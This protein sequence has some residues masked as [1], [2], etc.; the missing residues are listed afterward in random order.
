MRKTVIITIALALLSSAAAI[1]QSDTLRVSARYTTHVIF[2]TDITYADKSDGGTIA[3]KVVE[4]NKNMIALKARAPFTEPCSV[5]ALESNGRMWTFIVVYDDSP[6]RLIVDTRRQASEVTEDSSE[7][8]QKKAG[9]K[10]TKKERTA[11][12]WKSG[13]A[14]TLEEVS[15]MG[16][17]LHHIGTSGYGVTVLCENIYSYSDITYMVFSVDN[18]SGISYDVTDATFVIESR[19]RSKRTVAYDQT[20]FPRSRYGSLTAG[21]GQKGRIVYS[22]DKMTLSKDQA[23]RVYLY[24]NGGQRNLVMTVSPSDINRAKSLS[25]R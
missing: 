14:P 17:E 9:K 25:G 11:S 19:K 5:S 3:A 12:T 7:D 21:P 1:A 15:K 16:R 18:T 8:R 4:Q 24:E 6:E 2:S 23:L 13:D 10:Q 22:F 20:V